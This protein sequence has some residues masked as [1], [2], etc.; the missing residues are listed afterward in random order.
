MV[1][2][3]LILG[4]WDMI[5]STDGANV[6]SGVKENL[7]KQAKSAGLYGGDTILMYNPNY[8]EDTNPIAYI[9]VQ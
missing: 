9:I 6:R 5:L 8:Y 7:E 2:R 1:M 4:F 3:E